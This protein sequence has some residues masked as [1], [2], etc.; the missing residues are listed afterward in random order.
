MPVVYPDGRAYKYE[1]GVYLPAKEIELERMVK[2]YSRDDHATM[3]AIQDVRKQWMIECSGDP[4][5]FNEV[6][7]THIINLKNGLYDIYE[8][9][10]LPHSP[11]HHSL[12][13][14]DC[15]Y[16]PNSKCERFTKFINQALPPESVVLAQE[17]VGYILVLMTQAQKSFILHGPGGTGKSTFIRIIESL[18]GEQNVLNIAWQDLSDKFRPAGLQGKLLNTF[19]DLPDT[20]MK[21]MGMFKSLTGGDRVTSER[22]NKDPFEFMNTARFLFSAN[23]LPQNFGDNGD[24]F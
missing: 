10:L 7:S 9:R 6:S 2:N 4:I 3:Y 14:L 20:A 23:H 21:D 11:N 8:Q 18:V 15:S 13:Q 1:N 22:K 19:A 24:S 5:T 12:I 17:I 16:E